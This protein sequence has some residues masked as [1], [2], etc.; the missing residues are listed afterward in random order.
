MSLSERKTCRCTLLGILKI[1]YFHW[2]EKRAVF[3]A[4]KYFRLRA[5]G[6]SLDYLGDTFV[7]TEN[8]LPES[9]DESVIG[10]KELACRA[11]SSWVG[12]SVG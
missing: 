2:G 12:T 11:G 4:N 9:L 1:I 5:S 8:A 10:I 6:W 7:N 3:Y